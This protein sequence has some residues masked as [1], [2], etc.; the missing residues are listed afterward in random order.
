EAAYATEA[1]A[2]DLCRISRSID[3]LITDRRKKCRLQGEREDVEDSALKRQ[4]FDGGDDRSP[5]PATV[6]VARYRD[7]GNLS[8]RR[9]IF[10]ERA[11]RHNGPPP[12]YAYHVVVNR[13]LHHLRCAP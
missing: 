10:L 4:R 13:Q 6:H 2:T 8:D 5:D 3:T 1:V 12:R 11:A 9:R 7:R